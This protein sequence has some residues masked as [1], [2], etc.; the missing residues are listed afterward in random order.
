MSRE[1][2]AP[3][4]VV[5]RTATWAPE[6]VAPNVFVTVVCKTLPLEAKR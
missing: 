5:P 6:H 2:E 3:I 1:N 4:A